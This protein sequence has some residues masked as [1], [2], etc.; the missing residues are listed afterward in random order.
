MHNNWTVDLSSEMSNKYI[1]FEKFF[2][3][4]YFSA[5][6]IVNNITRGSI[7][8]NVALSIR[9]VKFWSTTSLK[10]KLEDISSVSLVSW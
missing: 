6:I 7:E 3:K 1:Y 8:S 9:F 2:Q 10:V 5:K 4:I